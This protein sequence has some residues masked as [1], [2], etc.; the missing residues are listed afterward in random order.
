[1]TPLPVPKGR[2]HDNCLTQGQARFCRHGGC[3][4]PAT[5]SVDKDNGGPFPSGVG[6]VVV[7]NQLLCDT[8]S[9]TLPVLGGH[10]TGSTTGN[11]LFTKG[12][13]G[14]AQNLNSPPRGFENATTAYAQAQ[15]FEHWQWAHQH[16][17]TAQM[18]AGFADRS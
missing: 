16:A 18:S 5:A 7:S 17:P 8:G 13:K 3:H 9:E 4:V 12:S 11:M 10:A 14:I 6:N 2:C 1:M 15:L